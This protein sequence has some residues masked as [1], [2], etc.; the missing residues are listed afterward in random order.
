MTARSVK[1]LTYCALCAAFCCIL[2][3]VCIFFSPIPI[4]CSMIGVYIC[5]IILEPGYAAVSQ[6]IYLLLGAIGLPVFAGFTGGIGVLIGPTGGYFIG[7]LPAAWLVGVLYQNAV[8][9][10][11]RSVWRVIHTVCAMIAG[12]LVCYACGTAWYLVYSGVDVPTA[13][14]VCVVAFLPADVLKI[15]IVCLIEPALSSRLTLKEGS[16]R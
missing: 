10:K 5:G 12:L 9:C 7:Y 14:M 3:P 8:R 15:A 6:G 13:L 4:T 11:P 2:S 16:C 1:T